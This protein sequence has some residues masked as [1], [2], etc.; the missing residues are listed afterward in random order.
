MVT[1]TYYTAVVHWLHCSQ[2]F[3]KIDIMTHIYLEPFFMTPFGAYQKRCFYTAAGWNN[4]GL[5]GKLH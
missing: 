4:L 3:Q 2:H 1:A 5:L